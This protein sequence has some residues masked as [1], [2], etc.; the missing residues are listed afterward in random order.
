MSDPGPTTVP[1]P[2]GIGAPATRALSAAGFTELMEL[3]GIPAA[4]PASLHGVGPKALRILQ[5]E[6]GRLGLALG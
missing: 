1:L 6:L 4:Q 5:E 2:P 3:D